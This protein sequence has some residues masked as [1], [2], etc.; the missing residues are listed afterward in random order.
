MKFP[1]PLLF[2]HENKR[3]KGWKHNKRWKWVNVPDDERS[4]KMLR[5][6]FFFFLP[7][8]WFPPGTTDSSLSKA[9][10]ACSY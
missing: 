1:F 5:P 10:L 7:C 9:L 2:Q 3:K 8:S 6:I 4:W